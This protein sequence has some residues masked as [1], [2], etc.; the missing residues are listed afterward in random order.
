[1]RQ[2]WETPEEP[3]LGLRQKALKSKVGISRCLLNRRKAT[4]LDAGTV[5]ECGSRALESTPSVGD[6]TGFMGVW[7]LS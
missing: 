7:G 1:M 3:T 5:A 2:T 6:H 4:E